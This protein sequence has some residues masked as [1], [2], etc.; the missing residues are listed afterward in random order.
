MSKGIYSKSLGISSEDVAKCENPFQLKDW[1]LN[2]YRDCLNIKEGIEFIKNDPSQS[3]VLF[4]RRAALR[5]QLQLLREIAIRH[6]EAKHGVYSGVKE[7]V[8]FYQAAQKMLPD[9]I[10]DRI[11]TEAMKKLKILPT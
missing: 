7:I 10:K 2:L 5:S 3:E 11:N 8:A 6:N 9:D 1:Y 4:K